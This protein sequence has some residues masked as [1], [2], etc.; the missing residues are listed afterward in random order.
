MPTVVRNS[1]DAAKSRG[2]AFG[3]AI[4]IS[5]VRPLPEVDCAAAGVAAFSSP[6]E[7]I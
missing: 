4:F 2:V 3:L 1:D 6:D 5:V 7:W